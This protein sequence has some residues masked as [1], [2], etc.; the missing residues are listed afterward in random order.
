M[1]EQIAR[2]IASTSK[3]SPAFFKEKVKVKGYSLTTFGV[4][5]QLSVFRSGRNRTSSPISPQLAANMTTTTN[6]PYP[7][8]YRCQRESAPLLSP[9]QTDSTV[10]MTD[11]TRPLS[12]TSNFHSHLHTHHISLHFRRR[13]P[14]GTRLLC[15][16]FSY[17][18]RNSFRVK[19]QYKSDDATNEKLVACALVPRRPITNR[20]EARCPVCTAVMAGLALNDM[21]CSHHSSRIGWKVHAS[22]ASQ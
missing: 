5:Q 12:L 4:V 22:Y 9:P 6:D 1:G 13:S 11:G 19:C 7:F 15:S 18:L 2:A 10:I 16:H 20:K 17:Y 3:G 14:A 8:P 21:S